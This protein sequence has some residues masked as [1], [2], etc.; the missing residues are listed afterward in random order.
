MAKAHRLC[1]I[2]LLCLAGCSNPGAPVTPMSLAREALVRG[3][4]AWK[5]GAPPS[6]L[7]TATPRIDFIDFE[8]AA[9][10][11]LTDFAVKG[12]GTGQG[13]QTFEV[14]L[15][16]AGQPAR[17]VKYLILGTDPVQ[18]YR[19]QDFDRAMNMDNNPTPTRPKAR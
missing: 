2:A 1:L 10:R 14:T 9:K 6:S 11:K 19:D 16:L 5:A 8:W 7:A 12:D 17:D 15:T 13:T 18:V 3:L 4:E